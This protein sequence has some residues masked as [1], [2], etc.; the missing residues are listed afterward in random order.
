MPTQPTGLPGADSSDPVSTSL[1]ASATALYGTTPAFWGR[2]FSTADATSTIEYHA[3]AENAVLAASGIRLLPI[4][5]QT[6]N[7]GGTEAQGET[8]AL[9]NLGALLGAFDAPTLAQLGSEFLVFLDVEGTPENGS[10][11]LALDYF[12]GW[13]S[14]LVSASKAQSAGRVTF[15]PAVYARQ[16]DTTTWN[17]LVSA[18]N[19]SVPCH[20]AWVARY[21]TSGCNL[22]PWDPTFVMPSV[23]LPC[24]VLLWQYQENCCNNTID[25]DQA[26]PTLDIQTLLLDR[27]I[28]PPA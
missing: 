23:A 27:L 20:G 16:G 9:A 26:N 10:P 12:L 17:V 24:D 25:C 11:S 21:H 13:A 2:Y 5:R 28:L 3:A 6:P 18:A 19:Q 1:I 7:V 8:D 4:A 15:L 22:L 14:T